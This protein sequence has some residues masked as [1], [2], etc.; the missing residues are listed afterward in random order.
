VKKSNVAMKG[1]FLRHAGLGC[2]TALFVDGLLDENPGSEV[3]RNVA[4]DRGPGATLAN[5]VFNSSNNVENM[6][7]QLST[8]VCDKDKSGRILASQDC[9]LLLHCESKV[10]LA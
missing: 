6:R 8:S 5:A 2:I 10:L 7:L 9:L 4:I 1:P 3:H